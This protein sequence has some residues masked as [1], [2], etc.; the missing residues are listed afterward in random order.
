MAATIKWR[1]SKRKH[2]KKNKK[3][4]V[5]MNGIVGDVRDAAAGS[6]V[7]GVGRSR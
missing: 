2:N 7:G 1:K 4:N 5:E 6:G 3:K